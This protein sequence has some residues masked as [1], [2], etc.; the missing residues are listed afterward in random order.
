M[1]RISR[2]IIYEADD[3]INL[4]H[5]MANS[6]CEGIHHRGKIKIIVINLQSEPI[7]NG[8]I[9]ETTKDMN[10]IDFNEDL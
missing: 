7:I 8:F 1:A 2:L 10:E 6:L 9:D 3:N 4:A 5:Q